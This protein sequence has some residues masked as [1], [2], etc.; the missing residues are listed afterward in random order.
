MSP[1]QFTCLTFACV[2][3]YLGLFGNVVATT[4][5]A[6]IYSTDFPSKRIYYCRVHDVVYTCS[7]G[8]TDLPKSQSIFEP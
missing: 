5:N 1:I 3:N 8:L 7:Q 2:Q 6:L 4:P